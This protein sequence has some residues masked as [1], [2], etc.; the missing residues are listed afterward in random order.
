MPCPHK[1]STHGC[2]LPCS[3]QQQVEVLLLVI[4]EGEDKVAQCRVQGVVV[5]VFLPAARGAPMGAHTRGTHRPTSGHSHPWAHTQQGHLSHHP[6][7]S[8]IDL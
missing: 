2:P 8:S 4:F 5:E 7:I 6:M 1:L 3:P